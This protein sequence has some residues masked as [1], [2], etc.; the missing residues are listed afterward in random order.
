MKR[1]NTASK[2]EIIESSDSYNIV[3]IGAG[4]VSTHISRH[5]H[6][7]GH[8]ISSVFSRTEE[9]A[10]RLA[11]E[12]GVPGTSNPEAV[13]RDADFYII[14]VPDRVVVEMGKKFSH[15][16]GIWLHTAGALSLDIFQNIFEHYGVL[17]P[18]Q[19]LSRIRPMEPS[20]VP[21]LVEG[22]SLQVAASLKKLASSAYNRVV[23]ATSEQRLVIHTAA[24]FANN[25]SNHMVHIARQLL[26]DQNI[27]PGLLDPLLQETFEKI[28]EM[29][30]QQGR[31]GPAVRGDQET[32]KKHIELLKGH[33]EWEK[34]YTFISRDI[35][36]SRD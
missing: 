32:I 33:P 13:P 2:T 17:Y 36:R 8:R 7:A 21:C 26:N 34:L 30:T 31:T 3:M 19:T 29:G 25:F 16:K 23:E 6:S 5:F 10:R 9:S 4:N 28:K 11:G 35:E 20:Q 22:S 15:A 18:L 14:A 24:V 1:T 12:L 27:D